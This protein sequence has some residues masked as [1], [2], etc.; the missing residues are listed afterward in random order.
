MGYERR[1][2]LDKMIFAVD[3][4]TGFIVACTLVRPNKSLSEVDPKSVRK[5][6][7]DKSFARSVVREDIWKGIEEL[8]VDIEAQVSFVVAALK[9]VAAQIGVNP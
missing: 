3:E 6:L 5:K 7:K 8:G 4:L 2:M 1:S 9:P